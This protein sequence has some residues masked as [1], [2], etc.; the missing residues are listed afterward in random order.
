MVKKNIQERITSFFL[1]LKT[2]CEIPI[3]DKKPPK[4]SSFRIHLKHVRDKLTFSCKLYA[5]ILLI[6][7]WFFKIFSYFVTLRMTCSPEGDRQRLKSTIQSLAIAN[8]FG[9]HNKDCL[10]LGV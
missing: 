7:L 6:Y 3:P 10:G 1:L 2:V 4:G 5:I 8:F 9:F